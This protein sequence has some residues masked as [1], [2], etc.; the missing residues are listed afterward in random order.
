RV[1]VDGTHSVPGEQLG[2]QPGHGHAVLEHVG[3]PR[4][5]ADVVLEHAPAAI[6][7]ADQVAPAHV[8]VDA[9]GRAYAVHG[10]REAR[11][12]DD[13]RPGHDPGPHD[14]VGV[15]DVVDER[16][17]GADALGQPAL[18]GRPLRRRLHP[19]D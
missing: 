3:D 9:A 5:G 11:A 2:H 17:K 12:A 8:A 7:V 18:D 13:Q 16:V 10:A 1:V 19:R 4:G 15:V 6:A 14:L